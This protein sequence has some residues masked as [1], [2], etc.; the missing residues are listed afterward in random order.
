MKWHKMLASSS[1]EALLLW[2]HIP[3]AI[4]P[5]CTFWNVFLYVFNYI[6]PNFEMYLSKCWKLFDYILKCICEVS[7]AQDAGFIIWRG[8]FSRSSLI[9]HKSLCKS[10]PWGKLYAYE[11]LKRFRPQ[12]HCHS[13]KISTNDFWNAEMSIILKAG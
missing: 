1:G 5:K 8:F 3:P 13:D 10:Q 4:V 2:Q 12:Y 7:L 11:I 9:S 6:C